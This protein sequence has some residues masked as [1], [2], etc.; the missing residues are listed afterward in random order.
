MFAVVF[1]KKSAKTN[2]QPSRCELD[3]KTI[4][5]MHQLIPPASSYA[6]A[7]FLPWMSNSRG[8]GLLS[9]QIRRVGEKKRANAPS[10]VNT[11]TFFI[12]RP[13]EQFHFKHFNVRFFVSINV[14]LCNSA[15]ILTILTTTRRHAPVYGFSAD[16]KLLTLN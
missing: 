10:S 4:V 5:I 11:V 16:I 8:W 15:R 6:L 7:F 2:Y 1:S 3:F 12:D 14:F 13:V 9:C